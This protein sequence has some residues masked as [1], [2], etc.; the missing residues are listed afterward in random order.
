MKMNF[1]RNSM[2]MKLMTFFTILAGTLIISVGFLFFRS[3]KEA[4]NISKEKEFI[5]LAQET[6]NKIERYM[7]ERY[8][9]IQ[10]MVNSPLLK[11]NNIGAAVK[12]D[13]LNSVR[14]AYKAYDYIFITDEHGTIQVN[15]GE[16]KSDEEYKR[17]LPEVLKGNSYVSDFTYS[18]SSKSYVVYYA[19]PIVDDLKHIK[20]A[21]VE[22]MN[23]NSIADIVKNVKLGEKGY[24]Y[25]VSS[26]GE[27]IFSP[28]KGSDVIKNIDENKYGT[29]YIKHN[30][31][32]YFSATYSIRKYDTQRDNWYV[33]VEEPVKEAY[34]VSYRLRSYTIIVLFISL[35][36]VF[37][38]VTLMS[39]KITKPIKE[40]LKETQ[41]AAE[42][43]IGQNIN[44]DSRDE[45]GDL[46]DSFNIMLNNL[47]SM[48]QQVLKVSGEAASMEQVRQYTEK[49]IDN[50]QSA[51]ITIDSSGKITSFNHQAS[52]IFGIDA[53]MILHKNISDLDNENMKPIA[54]LLRKGL[55]EDLIYIKHIIKIKN[56][57]GIELP[58]MI[59]TS[60]QKD[61]SGKLLGVIG[62]FRSVEEVKQLEESVLRAKNL[63]AL[64]SLSAGM[65]HEIR[66]P[67]T[68]IK[69]YAQFIKTELEVDSE[70]YNDISVIIS[71]VDRLNNIIDRF[72]AFAKPGDLNLEYC[73]INKII[74]VV[75]NL[76]NRDNL[77]KNIALKTELEK[78]P[79]TKADFDQIEQVL[80]NI[81]INAI[82]AMPQGGT[83]SINT[84]YK[85]S[86]ETIE[87]EIADTGEGISTENQDKIFEPFFT[88][89]EKGTGLGLAICSRIVE[90][91]KGVI[92]VNSTS[93]AGTIFII[94]LP[95]SN[96]EDKVRL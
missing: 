54:E 76:I 60:L 33:A 50:V 16:L 3:T 21:V 63:E 56:N 75:I 24:A 36:I 95:V 67:L 46:A 49:F 73:D 18:E 52:Y 29:F 25:L 4:I 85:K 88:T 14:E 45:I 90:N 34:E 38:L 81:C 96:D 1:K 35:F 48:M 55:E 44:I 20:G 28:F 80:L 40:L 79:C 41:S 70:L 31:I 84:K 27:Y 53:A 2:Q 71:E 51:I 57:R 87:I 91:H 10:V 86:Y 37:I 9:D 83:L 92:E 94:K 69:G 64:G 93:K 7:F 74:G 8:G 66:N 5:T 17:F 13:Y 32:N 6:S 39:K 11:T 26:K 59:N 62:V 30:N 82:Q 78:L 58:I 65:A 19:A 72:L 22:R 12:L 68:S 43:D 15:S 61:E 42:G 77:M 47:K 23:F 89:K